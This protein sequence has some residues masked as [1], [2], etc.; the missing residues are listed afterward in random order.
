MDTP[1]IGINPRETETS[2]Y[3]SS[4]PYPTLDSFQPW[5]LLELI[6][7]RPLTFAYP[8]QYGTGAVGREPGL[9]VVLMR[10]DPC[11]LSLPS[12]LLSRYAL[13]NAAISVTSGGMMD[14]PTQ[15]L[16]PYEAALV[17]QGSWEV[18]VNSS[19][20]SPEGYNTMLMELLGRPPLLPPLPPF[21]PPSMVWLAI[22]LGS[23]V[24]PV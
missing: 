15:V 19:G 16:T 17:T 22:A 7:I 10:V 9:G 23:A 6:R 2:S 18:L 8:Q 24:A 13:D 5:L 4:L 11:S 14:M 12:R 20:L 1:F 3:F 21:P